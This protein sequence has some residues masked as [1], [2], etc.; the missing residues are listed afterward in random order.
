MYICHTFALDVVTIGKEGVLY[1]MSTPSQ[2]F[3][4][5]EVW[6]YPKMPVVF[7]LPVRGAELIGTVASVWPAARTMEDVAAMSG[8]PFYLHAWFGQAC[9]PEGRPIGIDMYWTTIIMGRRQKQYWAHN[10][11]KGCTEPRE[12][13]CCRESIHKEWAYFDREPKPLL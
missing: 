13:W 4:T 10:L 3:P 8:M 11:L 7:V 12:W 6:Y 9:D 1:L 5:Y 2:T